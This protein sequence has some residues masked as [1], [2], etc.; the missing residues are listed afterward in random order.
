MAKR[1]I[2]RGFHDRALHGIGPGLAENHEGDAEG[3]GADREPRSPS[4][5]G[6]IAEREAQDE[7]RR[8]GARH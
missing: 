1:C 5:P 7:R 8:R 6:E 4:M 2:L 3:E